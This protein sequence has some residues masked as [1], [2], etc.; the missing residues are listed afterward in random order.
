MTYDNTTAT[1]VSVCLTSPVFK[2]WE[3]NT[4]N[5]TTSTTATN[6][7]SFR[8]ITIIKAAYNQEV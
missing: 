8:D 4:G 3:N 5:G 2:I 6:A 7:T 1:G